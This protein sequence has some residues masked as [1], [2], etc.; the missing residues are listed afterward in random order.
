MSVLLEFG[1]EPVRLAL[2]YERAA[3]LEG[4]YWRL[5]TGHL[6]HGG[7]AHLLLNVMGAALIATLFGRDYTPR[8]WLIVLL[9]SAVS[10][11]VGFVLFEPQLQWYVGL[12]GVLH[13]ALAAG[14]VAGWRHESR[15]LAL[16]LTLVLVGKLVWEQWQGALPLSGDM[17]VIVDAHLYGAVGGFLGALGVCLYLQR[18][19]ARR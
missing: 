9:A 7:I 3:V 5:L 8:Q 10:I 11:D 15:S 2:R 17:P 13:G 16:T 14:A 19:P 6:V 12:S 18:W 1:G 4:A